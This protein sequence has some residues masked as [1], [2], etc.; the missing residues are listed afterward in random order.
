V[1]KLV[2]A[3]QHCAA[4][5]V[6]SPAVCALQP[7]QWLHGVSHLCFKLAA[8]NA[9]LRVDG[10][11]DAVLVERDHYVSSDLNVAALVDVDQQ[12]VLVGSPV[13]VAHVFPHAREEERP[14][15]NRHAS[16]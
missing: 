11:R 10:A 5:R 12:R 8:I 16:H 6:E 3:T 14:L 4:I 1:A 15:Q 13:C 9:N 2:E 7:G